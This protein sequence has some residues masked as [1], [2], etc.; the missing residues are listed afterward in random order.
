MDKA[1]RIHEV[2]GPSVMKLEEVVVPAPEA[3]EAVVRQA[4]VGV[5]F[6]D[7]YHRTGLYPL[8]LPATI[9]LE[10]AGVVEAV[11]PDVSDVRPGDRVAYAGGPIGAYAERRVV[12]VSRLVPLPPEISFE[13]AAAATLKG[14]TAWYLIR[15]THRVERGESILVHAAAG[16]VGQILCQWAA[17]LGA[18]VI[19]AVGSEAKAEI[20]LAHGCAH[21]IVLGR[22]NFAAK[23]RELTGGEGVAVVYDSVGKATW[24]GSLDSLRP[25]G[26][27]VTFGNASGPVPPVSPLDLSAKGSLFLTRPALAH[28]TAR[29]EDVLEAARELFAEL[30]SGRVRVA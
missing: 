30:V 21:A 8:P 27:M 25:F 19:G 23:V 29:R 3:G 6:I 12:P 13:T 5:N 7:V 22:G 14:M 16:G 11:G 17:G 15:R 20:A 9:G 4:A 24:E 18:K 1:V 2:G 10:G 28:Y 26:L